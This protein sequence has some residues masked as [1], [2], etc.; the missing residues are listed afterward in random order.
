MFNLSSVLR[1]SFNFDIESQTANSITCTASDYKFN[2]ENL[3]AEDNRDKYNADGA[4]RLR[5]EHYA[6]STPRP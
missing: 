4:P 5:N 1:N 2:T 3:K 6:D